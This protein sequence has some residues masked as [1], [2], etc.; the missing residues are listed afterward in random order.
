[1]HASCSYHRPATVINTCFSPHETN[2][3]MAET[4]DVF[5]ELEMIEDLVKST[6]SVKTWGS[7]APD[8][9]RGLEKLLDLYELA[10]TAEYQC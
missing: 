4:R 3:K 1:M 8:F 7:I 5:L 9:H 2:P 6:V 10:V